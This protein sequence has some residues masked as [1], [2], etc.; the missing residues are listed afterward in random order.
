MA[1]FLTWFFVILIIA[2]MSLGVHLWVNANSADELP[3][4]QDRGDFDVPP[5]E[6]PDPVPLP[7]DAP[8][9][10][11]LHRN[12]ITTVE[13]LY[14]LEAAGGVETIDQIGPKRGERIREWMFSAPEML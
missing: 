8:H 5:R 12:G 2:L 7:D 10:E 3:I 6:V 9:R 13:E 11:V 14:E 1:T 4:E